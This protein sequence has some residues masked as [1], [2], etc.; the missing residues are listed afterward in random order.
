[1]VPGSSNLLMASLILTSLFPP[2]KY[3]LQL[4]LILQQFSHIRKQISF[5]QPFFLIL[6][7]VFSIFFVWF[8]FLLF[9]C[10]CDPLT[11]RILIHPSHSFQPYINSEFFKKDKIRK[12]AAKAE[13]RKVDCSE[14]ASL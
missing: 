12:E 4:I 5:V 2:K 1:M 11:V 13:K 10:S 7:F 6:Y 9:S 14:V 8:F 3:G